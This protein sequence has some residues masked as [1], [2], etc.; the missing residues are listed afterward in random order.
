M[1]VFTRMAALSLAAAALLTTATPALADDA[2]PAAG[3]TEAGTSFRTATAVEQGRPATAQGSTGDYLY[4]SFPADAGQRPVIE[5]EVTLPEAA[6]RHGAATWRLDVYDGLRRHQPCKYGM[7]SRTAAQD[8]SSVKLTCTLRT[9]RSWADTWS[10]EPLP[11]TYYIR[12]T[13]ARLPEE[14]LGQPVTARIE[15]T[16]AERGGAYA[17]DGVL[18]APLVPGAGTE[19]DDAAAPEGGW[20]SGWWTD[21]WIWTAAGGLVAALAGVWGHRL[22]RGRGRPPQAPTGA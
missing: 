6:S 13:V 8:A 15:A 16:S 4:W 17:V 2:E 22:T 14:D 11:G 19:G 10:N 18:G 21:R 12:L 3:P 5:A 20:S 1:R 9:V 7:P